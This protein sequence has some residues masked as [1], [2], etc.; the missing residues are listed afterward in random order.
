M[1]Q[2]NCQSCGGLVFVTKTARNR[3]RFLVDVEPDEARGNV[4]IDGFGRSH[5]F[6]NAAK[7][8]AHQQTH[9]GGDLEMSNQYVPHL[10][11]CGERIADP[12]GPDLQASL[13]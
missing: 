6:Q 13:L 11:T 2:K 5:V 8:A 1:D 12:V 3:R 4:L 7:A 9:P 10:V